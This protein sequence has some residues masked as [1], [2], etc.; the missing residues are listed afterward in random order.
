MTAKLNQ[1][2]KGYAMTF[3]PTDAK[4]ITP[5]MVVTGGDLAVRGAVVKSVLNNLVTL[6]QTCDG[7]K[8][9]ASVTF[10]APYLAL[11]AKIT[12]LKDA[13]ASGST[14]VT[15]LNA[16]GL[17]IGMQVA[18]PNIP[19]NA[20]ITSIDEDRVTI[21]KP[22]T[23][24][25]PTLT[26][27]P[28]TAVTVPAKVSDVAGASSKLT[29]SDA[30]NIS[31]GMKVLEQSLPQSARVT[32][33]S[34]NVVT[35]NV[36][37]RDKGSHNFGFARV[38][39]TLMT[40]ASNSKV[41][42]VA[43]P[44]GIVAGMVMKCNLGTAKAKVTGGL[45]TLDTA[46]PVHATATYV[47]FQGAPLVTQSGS[48]SAATMATYSVTSTVAAFK[49][50]ISGMA[51]TGPGVPSGTVSQKDSTGKITITCPEAIRLPE[52]TDSL[53]LVFRMVTGVT[54]TALSKLA[55]VNVSSTKL[56]I[57]DA[58]GIAVGMKV[59]ASGLTESARV[60]AITGNE[61]TLN[62]AFSESGQ[63]D[64]HFME[65]VDTKM[66]NTA[67]S[68]AAQV[69]NVSG[70]RDGMELRCDGVSFGIRVADIAVVVD[71]AVP[72]H[73]ALTPVSFEDAPTVT[74]SG[75][76]S[77]P[78]EAVYAL[79]STSALFKSVVDGMT[80][81]GF[82]VPD[83]ATTEQW[84]GGQVKVRCVEP[85]Y[86][87]QPGEVMT[88]AFKAVPTVSATS[89]VV[90]A[91][92]ASTNLALDDAT[93]VAVGMKV[94]GDT[95]PES[96][97]VAQVS[98][99]N[100]TL[101]VA[102]DDATPQDYDFL[103]VVDTMLSG[104]AGKV[105]T[106][107]AYQGIEPGMVMKYDGL[108]AT[109]KVTGGMVTLD[110]AIAAHTTAV[111]VS[112]Q[113]TTSD[114]VNGSCTATQ[115]AKYRVTSTNPLINNV[116]EGMKV[117]GPGV[118]PSAKTVI[119]TD[120]SITITCY[121][122]ITLPKGGDF[123]NLVFTSVGIHPITISVAAKVV[124]LSSAV[125]T[126]EVDDA[127]KVAIGMK[128]AG[129]DLPGSARVV[130]LSGTTLTVNAACT[131]STVNSISVCK[132]VDTLMTNAAGN[133]VQVLTTLGIANNMVLVA[134]GITSAP[135]VSG[136]KVT[137]DTT[138]PAPSTKLPVSF[139]GPPV[140]THSGLCSNPLDGAYT[141]T[142]DS[143]VFKSVV[144][145]M[146]VTGQGM[147][148]GA[149]VEKIADGSV[150]IR[151][152]EPCRA[153]D[154]VSLA[155]KAPVLK[156]VKIPALMGSV[157]EALSTLTVS[158]STGIT[159]GMKVTSA[160]LP[161][162]AR[163]AAVDGSQITLNVACKE[164]ST[165]SFSFYQV[166]DTTMTNIASSKTLQVASTDGIT[167]GMVLKCAGITAL[168][169][170]T[171]VTDTTVTVDTAVAAHPAPVAVTF[172]SATG[173]TR[174][175]HCS[176]AAEAVYT[177]DSTNV[178]LGAVVT[179]MT[180]T[181]TGVPDGA[182]AERAANGGL[183][184][185]VAE[186][187][188]LA[189]AGDAVSFLDLARS[190]PISYT[191]LGGAPDVTP[192]SVTSGDASAVVKDML[193]VI[194]GV[195]GSY[196]V[197]QWSGSS[198]TVAAVLDATS[199][200]K[201]YFVK[202]PAKVVTKTTND[203]GVND[204]TA[205]TVT[206]GAAAFAGQMIASQG[207]PPG[208]ILQAASGVAW[209]DAAIGGLAETDSLFI[210]KPDSEIKNVTLVSGNN[211]TVAEGAYT[212]GMGVVAPGLRAGAMITDVKS[213]TVIVLNTPPPAS[214]K[215]QSVWIIHPASTVKIKTADVSDGEAA[216]TTKLSIDGV[217]AGMQVA[218]VGLPPL[219]RVTGVLPPAVRLSNDLIANGGTLTADFFYGVSPRMATMATI[220]PGPD[221]NSTIKVPSNEGLRIGQLVSSGGIVIG[222]IT[223]LSADGLSVTLSAPWP[224]S[225]NADPQAEM[226]SAE[227][228]FGAVIA[229]N[230]LATASAASQAIAVGPVI[231]MNMFATA[232]AT[233]PAGVTLQFET[234]SR[235]LAEIQDGDY[236]TVAV[237][238][239]SNIGD[240][241]WLMAYGY[242]RNASP[243]MRQFY[244]WST[245]TGG[246]P[247]KELTIPDGVNGWFWG[248]G[249]G[250]HVVGVFKKP[251]LVL[252]GGRSLNQLRALRKPK[253]VLSRPLE[254]VEGEVSISMVEPHL[255]RVGS[256]EYLSASGYVVVR[257]VEPMPHLSY[258]VVNL[259][260]KDSRC[261]ITLTKPVLSDTRVRSL[262]GRSRLVFA[263]P[264]VLFGA[265][266]ITAQGK[267]VMQGSRP[268][269]MWGTGTMIV[270]DKAA[271][272]SVDSV[273]LTFTP[274][275]PEET[276][277]F[278]EL[279]RHLATITM[280][281]T[282]V[283][284]V[285]GTLDLHPG[286]FVS[287]RGIPAGARISA[288]PS[289]T[290]SATVVMR[291]WAA[292]AL[293][294]EGLGLSVRD[295]AKDCLAVWN[296]RGNTVS[297]S[298]DVRERVVSD[299]NAAMQ[300]IY[301][302]ARELDYFNLATLEVEVP[303]GSNSIPLSTEAQQIVGN[304]RMLDGENGPRIPLW[305]L[306][307]MA[308][309]E[310]FGPAYLGLQPGERGSPQAYYIDRRAQS[311]WNSV[312]MAVY[313]APT[314]KNSVILEVDAAM[315]PP[316]FHWD[317]VVKATP[318]RLP[319][320]YAET[321]LMPIVRQRAT[322]YKLFTNDS[323]KPAIE[324]QY[325]KAMEALGLLDPA[326][327]QAG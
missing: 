34:G 38:V 259:K 159:P 122:P 66:T 136:V 240:V 24:T 217:T 55:S 127:T 276:W 164:E 145:G 225:R 71:T 209:I 227:A 293:L 152:G 36:A 7:P 14:V 114:A 138:I 220:A 192:I 298:D 270:L 103:N 212:A 8:K 294:I 236:A 58:T 69:P 189:E 256:K 305:A 169:K 211:L 142:C 26:F 167:V 272:E 118:P 323:L 3:G 175:G 99:N 239:V 97:R 309:L 131:Q 134:D 233:G 39:D 84:P 306:K 268:T 35:L 77:D 129:G 113:P 83:G 177:V 93:D 87:G 178:A 279:P 120:H 322:A 246:E 85:L 194:E 82:N 320:A 80:V 208:L 252:D 327:N 171:A 264:P 316:R 141:V 96:A 163:V 237:E 218:A 314:P 234:Q 117:T 140:A 288:V 63:R 185:R 216:I 231:T 10:T 170:V 28:V 296:L 20:L 285:G 277:I 16:S 245:E 267:C 250:P 173:L 41:L 9:D 22:L 70:I 193:M 300:L 284:I 197:S 257:A 188:R 258:L 198:G 254:M 266:W 46:I 262:A 199:S 283:T 271:T 230:H 92:A 243:G 224:G 302:R 121:E 203:A 265:E 269:L 112:F 67:N 132:V 128:V 153:A 108:K 54:V 261:A 15:T 75:S 176:N 160:V 242:L 148:P 64:Y 105:L 111:P 187:L 13:A 11:P 48:C 310:Q 130:G 101:N 88:L 157:S 110:A 4:G 282:A 86:Y 51:V 307:S 312:G 137:V 215:D 318:L 228:I 196:K 301:S 278:D 116:T 292:A 291:A 60:K 260:T 30:S 251:N 299:I 43:N 89:K 6:H 123:T 74:Q 150:R 195:R 244:L 166:A 247:V 191:S 275:A 202:P 5:N 205:V 144:S 158:D 162:T 308:E 253:M 62:V 37:S 184:L 91:S 232:S 263:A 47:S 73:A 50:V 290:M 32:S 182:T 61:L 222:S 90:A 107:D 115:T 68:K 161:D 165:Q 21:N 65:V 303:V 181:G 133:V 23:T 29:V 52:G 210:T 98:A 143:A 149:V 27:T 49:N 274:D 78:V 102:C 206:D 139:E 146:T 321:L 19:A 31:A 44:D 151:C 324:E 235:T 119:E 18:G 221:G 156:E 238:V 213:K 109:V 104:P 219:C 190:I 125:S 147:A 289:G 248:Y 226:I 94:T 126:I 223:S 214:L 273:E 241:A 204:R 183:T 315:C 180:V 255:S 100:V 57:G 317:D 53:T 72:A 319:H 326:P 229:M 200:A 313:I 281:S 174:S 186:P 17:E 286:M 33:V 12:Q 135:K 295:V 42:Q 155:F 249:P 311:D 40:N 95:L 25:Q 1:D 207:V 297:I 179:G 168:V 325:Q 287:G 154:A 124:Y 56:T 172:Q 45:V 81:D 59:T 201:A 280:G 79:S 76:C 106:L 2:A 304:V